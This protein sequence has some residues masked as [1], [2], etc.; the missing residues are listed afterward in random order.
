MVY[1]MCKNFDAE[2]VVEQH[3]KCQGR[4]SIANGWMYMIYFI[5]KRDKSAQ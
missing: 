4:P 2:R 5:V 3:L 1:L